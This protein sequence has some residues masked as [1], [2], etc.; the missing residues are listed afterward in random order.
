MATPERHFARFRRRG[1]AADLGVCFDL[2]APRLL[3]LARHLVQDPASAEDL[4]Q[5]TFLL[6]LEKRGEFD[7][8]RSLEAWLVGLLTSLARRERARRARRPD[9]GRLELAEPEDPAEVAAQGELEHWLVGAL[10]PCPEPL[11]QVLALRLQRGLSSAAI[12]AQLSL[13]PGTVRSHLSRGLAWL[14]LRV[15]A[16]LAPALAAVLVHEGTAR[17][18]S[19]E[20]VRETVLSVGGR[21]IPL[22]PSAAPIPL[23]L[24]LMQARWTWIVVL[25]VALVGTG[26]WLE[27]RATPLPSEVAIAPGEAL[28]APDLPLEVEEQREATGARTPLPAAFGATPIPV[29]APSEPRTG[30]LLVQA[31]DLTPSM[32]P[33]GVH[34]RCLDTEGRVTVERSV[35]LDEAGRYSEPA[36]PP[37][38]W[39]ARFASG[40]WTSGMLSEGGELL[41]EPRTGQGMW[42]RGRVV[43]AAGQAV[44]GAIV[45]ASHDDRLELQLGRSDDEGR[46]EF[47]GLRPRLVLGANHPEHGRARPQE[48]PDLN[49]GEWQVELRL[50][51]AGA[52]LAIHVFGPQGEALDGVAV[53]LALLAMIPD[54]GAASYR[55]DYVR[56]TQLWV[57]AEG[58]IV[59][60]PQNAAAELSVFVETLGVARWDG[61]P[62]AGEKVSVEL[63]LEALG[64]VE[65]RATTLAGEPLAGVEISARQGGKGSART[66]P[67]GHYRLI[68]LT[69]G[70]VEL[71]ARRRGQLGSPRVANLT[72]AADHTQRFDPVFDAIPTGG[73]LRDPNGAGLRI[74][75]LEVFTPAGNSLGHV[76]TDSDGR[77]DF[78]VEPT[79]REV[80]LAVRPDNSSVELVQGPFVVPVGETEVLLQLPDDPLDAVTIAAEVRDGGLRCAEATVFLY[81]CEPQRTS[82][83]QVG[84][85]PGEGRIERRGLAP[86]RWKVVVEAPGRRPVVVGER[87]LGPGDHWDLG[88]VELGPARE[89]PWEI[90]DPWER[91]RLVLEGD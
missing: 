69:P 9:P 28:R 53:D 71:I 26:L 78:A 88:P 43:D 68:G 67:T 3:R 83:D 86:G 12:A 1:R 84:T 79:L 66:D 34:L 29:E 2:L 39:T 30:R 81:R 35:E 58:A 44:A 33:L 19:L 31:L 52:I 11:R 77:F 63:R 59:R 8:R 62:D 74:A 75:Q 61:F 25:A 42:V 56:Y 5:E 41:L 7:A 76:Y 80:H 24:L 23:G 4:V 46:F 6:A 36:A 57:P 54:G 55:Q 17:G 15:P 45:F 21:L 14:R 91:L 38:E 60:L 27:E 22:A 50:A 82:Y 89:D 65:G 40:A 47:S 72:V 73:W 32:A 18:E 37:G 16:S 49:A 51:E 70:P 48:L 20:A 64:S 85:G 90:P 13:P 10:E 87:E